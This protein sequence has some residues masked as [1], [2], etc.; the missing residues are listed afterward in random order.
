M[1]MMRTIEKRLLMVVV[2]M[3][4]VGMAVGV[5]QC[6]LR[7]VDLSSDEELEELLADI[8]GELEANKKPEVVLEG[9]AVLVTV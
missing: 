1:V 8:E 5:C 3:A 7:D 9:A 4:V 6:T 2:G